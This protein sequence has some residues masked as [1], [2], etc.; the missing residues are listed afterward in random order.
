VKYLTYLDESMYRGPREYKK[1]SNR[2]KKSFKV[3]KFNFFWHYNPDLFENEKK[4]KKKLTASN[5][6]VNMDSYY[7]K[8]YARAKPIKESL[9]LMDSPNDFYDSSDLLNLTSNNIRSKRIKNRL[10]KN[11]LDQDRK[12]ETPLNIDFSDD[13]LII[14]EGVRK[15]KRNPGTN[16]FVK[17]ENDH[18]QERLNIKKMGNQSISNSPKEQKT[19]KKNK[20]MFVTPQLFPNIN[21]SSK[22]DLNDQRETVKKGHILYNEI[23]EKSPLRKDKRAFETSKSSAIFDLKSPISLGISKAENNLKQNGENIPY[24]TPRNEFGL[25]KSI[26]ENLKN[27]EELF[28]KKNESAQAEKNF[29]FAESKLQNL[30]TTSKKY[31][32]KNF[33]FLNTLNPKSPRTPYNPIV[34]NTPENGLPKLP[35]E[36]LGK[37]LDLLSIPKEFDDFHINSNKNFIDTSIK[38]IKKISFGDKI[39]N[40]NTISKELEMKNSEQVFSK[41]AEFGNIFSLKSK[42]ELLSKPENPVFQIK[43]ESPQVRNKLKKNPQQTPKSMK[44]AIAQKGCFCKNTECLKNYCSCF[45]NGLLC[46]STCECKNCENHENSKRRDEKI[47]SIVLKSQTSSDRKKDR[48]NRRQQM[49]DLFNNRI[50]ESLKMTSQEFLDEI[51]KKKS[52]LIPDCNRFVIY[53]N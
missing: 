37:Q 46:M 18:Y 29:N 32:S 24:E 41:L 51:C 14:S 53:I 6:P 49:R 25:N 27:Y 17:Y 8:M 3:K 47:R 1:Q 33:S 38:Q 5:K 16:D 52:H 23:L 10:I 34:P 21:S 35:K 50:N 45:K 22:T 2:E 48:K 36:M 13:R 15:L 44:K 30:K 20:N 39:E 7:K 11:A 40:S 26:I 43:I 28:S 4:R 42:T 31:N 19:N 12:L 9:Y